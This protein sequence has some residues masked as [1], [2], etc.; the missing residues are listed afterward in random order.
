MSQHIISEVLHDFDG[1]EITEYEENDGFDEFD[2]DY[3]T[4]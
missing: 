3:P 1:N 2:E 4:D